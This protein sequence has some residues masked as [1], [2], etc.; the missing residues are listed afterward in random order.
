MAR[1]TVIHLPF[2]F[3]DDIT[4]SPTPAITAIAPR[5]GGTETRS[6]SRMEACSGPIATVSRRL[7]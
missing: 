1:A 6:C 4:I 7:E 3:F 2:R 5:I